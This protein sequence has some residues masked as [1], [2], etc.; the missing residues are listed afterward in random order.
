MRHINSLHQSFF[1]QYGKVYRPF[2]HQLNVK[3]HSYGL[4]NSQWAILRLLFQEGQMTP[5]EIA[6]RQQVEKPSVT[7][8]LQRLAEMKYVDAMP[9]KDR[10]EKLISLTDHGRTVVEEITVQL[11]PLYEQL[12][13]G[14]AEN[15]I[16]AAIDVLARVHQNLMR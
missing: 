8:I 4:F 7:K 12:L 15:E 5:A 10:R 14:V 9:G 16:E 1:S 6:N 3:L 13:E 11:K 2:I